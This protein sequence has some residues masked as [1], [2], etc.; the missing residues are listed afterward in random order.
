[1]LCEIK[2]D[3][4]IDY[5]KAY[6]IQKRYV[7]KVQQGHPSIIYVCEHPSVLTLGR[8]AMAE[9]ILISPEEL[10][11]RGIEVL[12]ID[13]GGDITLHA[14]GQL[15]IYPILDLQVFGKDLRAYLCKL[16]QVAIDL[17][18][19]FGIVAHRFDG[20]TGVWIGRKK[21]VSIGIG[22]RRWISYHGLAINVNTDLALFS[23]IKPCG[24]DVKMTS[25][26][27]IKRGIIDMNEVKKRVISNFCQA[28]GLTLKESGDDQ[29]KFAVIESRLSERGLC[30]REGARH[31]KGCSP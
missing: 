3:G 21:I 10:N 1:M 18:N 15:V 14:P 22:V 23:M 26:A 16:E 24:M 13:R 5:K 6:E 2:D 28:F 29:G 17:L 9:H 8:S 25:M 11:E 20:K 31:A 7:Q 30:L 19:C 4:L 12:P 27:Q